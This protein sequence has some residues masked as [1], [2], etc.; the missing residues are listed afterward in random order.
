MAENSKENPI[1]K[2][3]V[4]DNFGTDKWESIKQH[5]GVDTDFLLSNET[6]DD[7]ITFKLAISV[8]HVMNIPIEDILITFG[9]YWILKTGKEKYG[10]LMQAGGKNLKEFLVKHLN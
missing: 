4:L 2:T 8:S 9:E 6:Y 5:S 7:E 10:N 3:P 1:K